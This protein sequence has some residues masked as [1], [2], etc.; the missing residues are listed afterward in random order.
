M[1]QMG[2]PLPGT[3]PQRKDGDTAK[4]VGIGCLIAVLVLLGLLA[5]AFFAGRSVFRRV[6]ETYTELQPRV[7]PLSAMPADQAEAVLGRFERFR[8]AVKAGTASEPLVLTAD[9]VNG[10]IS[11]HPDGKRAAGKVHVSIE[12]S[13]IGAE[14]SVPL[15]EVGGMF[16][17]RFLNGKGTFTALLTGGRLVIFLDTLELA[18]KHMPDWLMPELR[19]KNLAEKVNS[20]PEDAAFLALFESVSV[21]GGRLKVVPKRTAEPAAR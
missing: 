19:A 15:D 1:D 2:N 11:L 14:V 8:E 13:K 5:A 12:G 17:G 20:K 7:L 21:E 6:V 9:D 10:L 18:G 16:K 4:K 3:L